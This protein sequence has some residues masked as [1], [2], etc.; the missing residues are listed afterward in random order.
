MIILS[1]DVTA[2]FLALTTVDLNPATKLVGYMTFESVAPD[3]FYAGLVAE[4]Y[5][6]VIPDIHT[7]NVRRP[8]ETE[9][10]LR[11]RIIQMFG[12]LA[13][14]VVVQR[15]LSFLIRSEYRLQR[16]N[17]IKDWV[18]FYENT[19]ITRRNTPHRDYY[20]QLLC[21]EC[22]REIPFTEQ[23]REAVKHRRWDDINLEI[24]FGAIYRKALP[25]GGRPLS[26][27]AN[28][29]LWDRCQ[30]NIEFNEHVREE[31]DVLESAMELLDVVETA[32][33]RRNNN[34]SPVYRSPA[35]APHI[36]SAQYM[37]IMEQEE[38]AWDTL[39]VV[40]EP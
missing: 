15:R 40:A 18:A 35:W 17:L 23:V 11:D 22:F 20:Y 38:L 33:M 16:S 1:R 29:N 36:L 25:L 37:K 3:V 10:A 4:P 34:A 5:G 39:S 8:P 9:E 28:R 31:D 21:C 24:L 2:V 6:G 27:R 19:R 26:Q 14:P 7:R 13:R 30:E 32:M 12:G